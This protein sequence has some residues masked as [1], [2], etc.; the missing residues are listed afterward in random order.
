MSAGYRS[1]PPAACRWL[2]RWASLMVR[3]EVRAAWYHPREANLNSLWILAGRGELPGS[4]SAFLAW[5]CRDTLVNAFLMRCRGLDLRRWIRGPAFLMAATG[6]A[7]LLIAAATHGFAVTRSLL[8]VGNTPGIARQDRLVENFLPIAFAFAVSF[9]A[10]VGRISLGGHRW[11]YVAFLLLK[12]LMLA[13]VVPLLWIEGG[14]ALRSFISNQ[15]VRILIGGVLP[16]VLLTVAMGWMM[17]WS[18]A[19]QRHRCPVCLRLLVIPVRIGSWASVFEPVTTEWICDAG[20]GSLCVCEAE[21]GRR[22]N[23]IEL[24]YASASDSCGETVSKP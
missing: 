24:A 23:W 3:P 7:L 12:I 4:D 2:L 15:T 19:D 21:C 18:L 14:A 10:A 17:L 13:I 11:R 6:A 20:H 1:Q 9:M 5:W 22:D 16:A 8:A